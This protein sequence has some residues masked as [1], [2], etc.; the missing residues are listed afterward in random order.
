LAVPENTFTNQKLNGCGRLKKENPPDIADE[1]LPNR[2]KQ[3]GRCKLKVS[4]AQKRAPPETK[5]CLPK[6]F[7]G[8]SPAGADWPVDR[9]ALRLGLPPPRAPPN[10]AKP[11]RARTSA[12]PTLRR[13]ARN[14][15]RA[16]MDA[17]FKVHVLTSEDCNVVWHWMNSEFFSD[18]R[19]FVSLL[20]QYRPFLLMMIVAGGIIFVLLIIDT[21]R[22]R[23][24]Q[25]GRHK[26]LH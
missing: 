22:H 11:R 8:N 12:A 13:A 17:F 21:H 14:A 20:W 26:R 5:G 23:K 2:N 16:T 18:I 1:S 24:K 7:W 10:K 3:Q 15:L 9:V 6:G 4:A 25:R 19:D